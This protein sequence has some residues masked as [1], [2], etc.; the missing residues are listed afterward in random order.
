MEAPKAHGIFL[1]LGFSVFHDIAARKDLI[2]IFGK[3]KVSGLYCLEIDDCYFYVGQSVNLSARFT[4]HKK[5]Y[6]NILRYSYILCSEETLDEL[7][8]YCIHKAESSDIKILNILHA[9]HP[10]CKA[11]IDELFQPKDQK[12]WADNDVVYFNAKRKEESLINH[13]IR[14][15]HR[16]KFKLFMADPDAEILIDICAHYVRNCVPQPYSTEHNYWGISCCPSTQRG[17][18]KALFCFN[19]FRMETFVCALN[20]T[21][22]NDIHFFINVSYKALLE[23]FETD[24]TFIS[25]YPECRLR[26]SNYSTAGHDQISIDCF[27]Y[28][29]TLNILS[30]WRVCRP[31]RVM[32]MRL[33][34]RG[35]NFYKQYHSFQLADKIFNVIDEWLEDH[36][37]NT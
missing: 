9:S 10:I 1:E 25:A 30:D 5:T 15:K 33:M 35:F 8:Q 12:E 29:N 22:N 16:N 20:K 31:A 34:R 19:I 26:V 28:E 2:H 13:D 37:K 36:E 6:N 4:D 3:E 7:E 21:D 18:Y 23:S 27:D 17:Q 14:A 32:N 24:D 11:E